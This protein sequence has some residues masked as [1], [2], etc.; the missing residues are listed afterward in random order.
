MNAT[1]EAVTP[2]VVRN[3]PAAP[4]RG[5]LTVREVIDAY[6]S[7]Y[8]GRDSARARRVGFSAK[9]SVSRGFAPG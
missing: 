7:C 8:A 1:Y 5:D 9:N 3:F 4:N 2:T 6:M